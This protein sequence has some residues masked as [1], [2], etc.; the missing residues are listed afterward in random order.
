M[1]VYHG[2]ELDIRDDGVL[3]YSVD[4]GSSWQISRLILRL[5]GPAL[6]TDQSSA[7]GEERTIYAFEPDGQL[8]LDHADSRTWYE[9]GPKRAPVG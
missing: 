2:I 8:R 6:I 4:T 1:D 3:L 5:D 9:R 7:P